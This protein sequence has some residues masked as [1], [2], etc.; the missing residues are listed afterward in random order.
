VV[1]DGKNISEVL[2]RRSVAFNGKI[3]KTTK[4]SV[5]ANDGSAVRK[6]RVIRKQVR[7]IAS[8]TCSITFL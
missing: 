5:E 4:P 8:P 3:K 1:S 2:T 7:I 6:P